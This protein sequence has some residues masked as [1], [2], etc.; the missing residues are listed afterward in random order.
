MTI[1][2]I[3]GPPYAVRGEDLGLVGRAALVWAISGRLG[4][5]KAKAADEGRP[6]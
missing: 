6:R 4:M 2:A 3:Y 5:M 1:L